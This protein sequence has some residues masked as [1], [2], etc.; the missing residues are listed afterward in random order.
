LKKLEQCEAPAG[1]AIS[2]LC[3]PSVFNAANR[4][5]GLD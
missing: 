2:Q 3:V 5:F 4:Y 1:K